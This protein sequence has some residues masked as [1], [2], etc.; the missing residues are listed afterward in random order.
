MTNPIMEPGIVSMILTV[1][2][3]IALTSEDKVMIVETANFIDSI[4]MSQTILNGY[5]IDM[6]S[7]V[8]LRIF[9]V[10]SSYLNILRV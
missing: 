6:I 5:H 10:E 2:L 7:H 8:S 4:L 1:K 9:V 3:L